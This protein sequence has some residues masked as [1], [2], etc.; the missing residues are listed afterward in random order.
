MISRSPLPVTVLSGFLGAGKTTLLNRILSNRDGLRVAVIVN[1]M[2]E[3]NVDARLIRQGDAALRQVE[4]ELVEFSN[5]C[6][7]CTLREDLLREV[8]RLA[9]LQAFDY[10]L[11]E[12]TGISE[13]LPVAETFTF[14]DDTGRRLSDVARLDT[15]VTVVDAV[16]F[17]ND[18]AS[19]DDL[20][21]RGVALSEEDDRD[22]VQLLVEQVE[23]A[24]VL[25]VS[26]VDLATPERVAELLALLRKLNPRARLLTA[27]RGEVD[28]VELLNTRRFDEEW[29]S[30]QSDWLAVPR[31][32]EVSEA[33][34]YGFGS[35]VFRARR[36]FHAGRLRALLEGE[37]FNQVVRSKGVI[38]L[39]TRPDHAAEWSQAG[40][41]FHLHPAG[42]WAATTAASE[43]PD[44][45]QFRADVEAVWEEP[46]GDRRIE[47]VVIGQHL[48][49]NDVHKAL[50]ECL[51]ND[52]ELAGGPEVWRNGVDDFA[53]WEWAEGET[54]EREVGRS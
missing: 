1:D 35:L 47:L 10:L 48:S 21:Q 44:D 11:I 24:N 5:G 39:A 27:V 34:E 18:F 14:E 52:A 25:V 8:R 49:E 43:W 33:A 46:W 51:L 53:P 42:L 20:V 16:N 26:K 4:E 41:V 13:P 22:L 12:S 40:G 28:L 50:S 17:G 19:L 36:P 2:S 30:G 6:I 15:L 45:P 29:A 7:C 9:E 32:A 38:W 31:G 3:I 54:N 23:F 37:I